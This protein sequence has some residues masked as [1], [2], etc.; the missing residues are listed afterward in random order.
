MHLFRYAVQTSFFPPCGSNDTKCMQ[1]AYEAMGSN[2]CLKTNLCLTATPPLSHSRYV[3]ANELLGPKRKLTGGDQPV[4]VAKLHWKKEWEKNCTWGGSK[5]IR[6][7]KAVKCVKAFWLWPFFISCCFVFS[8]WQRLI[9]FLF[10][11]F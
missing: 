3:L 2:S 6:K 11:F 8:A 5:G 1:R 7:N 10:F 4:N 9:A